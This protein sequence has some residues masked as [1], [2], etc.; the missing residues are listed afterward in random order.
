[1]AQKNPIRVIIVDDQPIIRSGLAAFLMAY[2]HLNLV[3]EANDGEEALELCAMLRPDV[4]LMDIKMPVMDGITATRQIRQRWPETKVLIL[5]SFT[6]PETLRQAQEAGA[7]G[8]ILKDVG[9]DELVE[10]IQN[11]S[12]GGHPAPQGGLPEGAPARVSNSGY[13]AEQEM[14]SAGKIQ[15]NILP[16]ETPHLRGWDFS[17]GLY[18]ARETWGD[19]FDFIPLANG[20]WGI[21]IAD[22]TDKGMGAA[23]FMALSNT[24]IRT[25]ATQYPTLPAFALSQVNTRILSDTRGSMFV[26]A[27]YGVL[28]PDTGRLRY[29][30]AGHNPPYLV[31]SQKGKPVDRLRGTGM[32]LG[33]MEDATWQQK[34]IKFSPGDTL[35][36]YTDGITEAQ[37]ER[38][39]FFGEQRLMEV[40]RTH[41]HCRAKELQN[42]IFEEVDKFTRHT[43]RADDMT[44]VVVMRK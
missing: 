26:T 33:V 32:A 40:V 28:E 7:G 23:L 12:S 14:V 9:A 8:Y 1:M 30:N 2:D 16:A 10:A 42:T 36:M 31:S 44:L 34:T 27:F 3:G 38:G 5:T 41:R 11:L 39:E 22:V 24:L 13:R 20:N 43:P 35:V 37:N 4:V 18:S 29:V 17:A 6:E 19:F 21:L 25:Y 15:A